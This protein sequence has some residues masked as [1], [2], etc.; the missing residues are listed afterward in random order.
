MDITIIYPSYFRIFE[1]RSGR[2]FIKNFETFVTTSTT[3]HKDI[4][5]VYGITEGQVVI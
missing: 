1:C 2:W 5:T 4:N 3:N